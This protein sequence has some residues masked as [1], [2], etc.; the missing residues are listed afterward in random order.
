M[1]SLE[2]RLE[3]LETREELTRAYRP[4]PSAEAW[5]RMIDLLDRYA[6]AKACGYVPEELEAEFRQ[7]AEAVE[8]PR[9][10]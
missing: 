10:P 3:D 4:G 1:G 8:R 5:E 2:K 7:A 6:V 9:E